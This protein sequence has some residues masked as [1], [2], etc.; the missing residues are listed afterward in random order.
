MVVL[1][2]KNKLLI[3]ITMDMAFWVT[4]LGINMRSVSAHLN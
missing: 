3:G 1:L 2:N 4:C